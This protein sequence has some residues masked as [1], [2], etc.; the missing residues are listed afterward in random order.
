MG[1]P[2]RTPD[3]LE[4]EALVGRYWIVVAEGPTDATF[5][6]KWL[7][8]LG[9]HVVPISV[10]ELDLAGIPMGAE[11]VS[12]NRCKVLDLARHLPTSRSLRFLIDLDLGVDPEDM[13][14]DSLL[15]TD[16][17]SIE[18][19]ALSDEVLRAL[20]VHLNRIVYTSLQPDVRTK[21][22]ATAVRV[23]VE[24]LASYLCPL[25]RLRE[26]HAAIED[27]DEFVQDLRKF[28]RP[29][30]NELD[31]E[32]V[33]LVLCLP[34][35]EA[36]QEKALATTCVDLRPTAYGHDIARAIWAIWPDLRM[37]NGIVDSDD[38]ERLLLSLVR[39]DDLRSFDLFQAI[40]AW[41]A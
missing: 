39:A 15:V 34:K 36:L 5:L 20:L 29:G 8:E 12:S 19:Y 37:K 26:L 14:I 4:T 38:L 10:T 11:S 1:L 23:L 9:W 2:S 6:Q 16:F 35:D 13:E 30:T 25:F 17:P 33:R 40:E 32:K 21:E 27:P 24:Q 3:E 22:L 41:A 28:R 31:V 18:T 7:I